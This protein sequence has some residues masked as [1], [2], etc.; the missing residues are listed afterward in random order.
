MP[1]S[2]RCRWRKRRRRRRSPEPHRSRKPPVPEGDVT[3]LSPRQREQMA[4][5]AE[6]RRCRWEEIQQRLAR[7]ESLR[8]I[9]RE[10]GLSRQT[11]R[12]YARAQQV[13]VRA[14]RR[15]TPRK[16]DPYVDYLQQ[17]W[18]TGYRNA[19]QLYAEVVGRG[20]TGSLSPLRQ[21]VSR[22]RKR[23]DSGQRPR[24]Q[25]SPPDKLR[26]KELR[27]ILLKPREQLRPDEVE[28]L[29]K[30]LELHPE[31]ATAH[32]LA[33]AFR[34]LVRERRGADLEGWLR[35][36][37][38]SRL[39]P[40]ERPARTLRADR[41]AVEAGIQLPWSTGLVEGHINR[42]KFLKRLGYGR[43]SLV[44]LKARILGIA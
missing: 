36:A 26:W 14:P 40:F 4:A 32:H 13:P 9:A 25:G 27:W 7:K 38:Q 11:V 28:P 24:R 1:G 33:E 8:A 12:K 29:A 22:W 42:V 34:S 39:G 17:R 6:R 44:L 31:L 37:E 15:R 20:Y 21:L 19:R 3:Y 18:Q 23:S 30:A 43:A 5:S 16:L 41:V 2:G 10:M 35:A